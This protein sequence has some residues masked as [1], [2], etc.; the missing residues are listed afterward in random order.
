MVGYRRFYEWIVSSKFQRDRTDRLSAMGKEYWPSDGGRALLR[1]IPDTLDQWR[2]WYHYTDSI[3]ETVGTTFPVRFLNLHSSDESSSLLSQFLCDILDTADFACARSRERDLVTQ[4]T[5][6][7][8]QEAASVPSLY[9]DALATAAAAAGFVDEEAHKRCDVREAARAYQEETL[10]LTS[11]DLP[12]ECPS[13][14]QLEE[15]YRLSVEMERAYMP[16]LLSDEDDDLN[17]RDGFEAKVGENSYCWVNTTAV[18]TEVH[19]QKFFAQF[20]ATV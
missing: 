4:Q 10:G 14:A 18:L 9:Y 6:M 11:D 1:M 13:R 20:S 5:A 2:T 7:N 19:W 3:L 12:E 17:H 8:T 15:L 16:S